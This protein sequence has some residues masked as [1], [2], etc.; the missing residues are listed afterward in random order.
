MAAAWSDAVGKGAH[1]GSAGM[2]ERLLR[3]GGHCEITGSA[4]GNGTTVTFIIPVQLKN[5]KMIK[6][7]I[8]EDDI[9]FCKSLRRVTESKAEVNLGIAEYGT[10]GSGS[11]R[12]GSARIFPT[13]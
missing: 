10:G 9:R 6:V 5:M 12:A 4:G 11:D 13:W 8:V 2:R 7:A 1:H 3:L